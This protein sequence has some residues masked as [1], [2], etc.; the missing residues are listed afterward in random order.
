MNKLLDFIAY[1]RIQVENHSIYV[2]GAQGQHHPEITAKWI[3]EMEPSS[4]NADRAIR[5]WRAQCDA[6]YGDVLRAFDCSGLA[7]FWLQDVTN[8][9]DYDTTAAGLFT[10]CAE[11][12]KADLRVGDFVFRR[13]ANGS[14][15][16]VGYVVD[17]EL[18]VIEARGRDAGVLCDALT[19]GS[20]NTYGRPPFWT[21]R[22]VAEAQGK[23]IFTR[24]LKWGVI[25]D[26]VCELKKLLAAAGYGG[27][28]V[29]NKNYFNGTKVIV[30]AYQ[31]ANGLTVD[32]KAGKKTLTALGG[33]WD[34]K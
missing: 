3:R 26:D 31:A 27:L 19:N 21:E 9:L 12:N 4:S 23:P 13:D 28:N 17:N 24:T 14:V 16:H 6:G 22:E 34:G 32:G 18:N 2:W 11:I 29:D 5:Y 1:L 33:Y 10:L 15:K 30:R 8:I 20:W 7:M 25:G